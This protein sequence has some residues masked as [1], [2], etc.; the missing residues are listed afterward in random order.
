MFPLVMPPFRVEAPSPIKFFSSITTSRPAS[1]N[2]NAADKPVKPHPIMAISVLSD[3]SVAG[4][5]RG[6]SFFPPIAAVVCVK[7]HVDAKTNLSKMR[8]LLIN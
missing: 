3:Q 1:A 2:V 5:D 4:A 7:G 6:G 8:G